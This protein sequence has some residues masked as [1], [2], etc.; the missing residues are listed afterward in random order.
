MNKR[1][2]LT[3]I[4]NY[5]IGIILGC[6]VLISGLTWVGAAIS[7]YSLSGSEFGAFNASMGQLQ[8][9]SQVNSK[10]SSSLST[11]GSN[12]GPLGWLDFLIGTAWLGLQSI[13]IS[14]GFVGTAIMA[15]ASMIGVPPIIAGLIVS[16]P[17]VMIVFGIWMAILR[18]WN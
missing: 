4:Q 10:L 16:I 5:I 3:S 1:G 8:N 15:F 13:G 9:V 12:T 2:G 14:L 11:V 18:I 7:Q 6:I 17:V